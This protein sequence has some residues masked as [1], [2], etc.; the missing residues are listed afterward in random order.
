MTS[1]G[2]FRANPKRPALMKTRRHRF[3]FLWAGLLGVAGLV[4]AQAP[5]DARRIFEL[6][7]QDRQQHGLPSLRWDAA[8]A[9]AAQGH[10]DRMARQK[11]LS[12]QYAGEPELA[13]RAAS[14]GA[15][16]RAI[17]EN[18]ALGPNPQAIE[19]G[20]MKSPPHRANILD[21]KVDAIGVAVVVHDGSLYAVEDF[22]Q[23]SRALTP[24]QVEDRVREL[25]RMQNVDPSAPA[26]PAEQACSMDHGVPPRSNARAI[27][28]FETPDLSRLPD[29]VRQQIR[30]GDFRR[31]AVGACAPGA[32]QESFT[33]YRVAIVFY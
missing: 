4:H 21:A 32:S 22:E 23:S 6:T 9:D 19:Q 33:V 2:T 26:E 29:Q 11:T 31:A 18:I 13:Q 30:R 20:W 12:H 16:F 10:A 5:A 14:S 27:I 7:N 8:L 15:H 1:P 3:G 17:A 28:R 25:L 24:E